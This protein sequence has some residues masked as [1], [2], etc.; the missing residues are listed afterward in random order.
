VAAGC[1]EPDVKSQ[2]I[3][4]D[5]FNGIGPLCDKAES[6][7]Y[8]SPFFA[9]RRTARS[10]S[11]VIASKPPKGAIAAWPHSIIRA[12][13]NGSTHRTIL[14]STGQKFLLSEPVEWLC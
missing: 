14:R 9:A 3:T 5:F 7:V 11:T 1:P 2:T 13:G 6:P 8:A 12:R 4:E 10:E